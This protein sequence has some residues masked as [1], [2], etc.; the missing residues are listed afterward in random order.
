MKGAIEK[1]EEIA[2]T[3]PHCFMPQQFNNPANPDIHRRTTAQEIWA[4][5]DGNLDM[6]L[7][8]VG[9]GGT[10]S[11]VGE[12]L[13]KKKPSIKV[14]AI[15]PADSPV[16]S[17]GKPG[18]HKIQGIGAGFVPQNYHADVIDEVI[19]VTHQDAGL[20]ARELAR[21]EGILVGISS[22]AIVWAALEAAKR[23]ENAGKT[24]VAMTC[25]TGE[26][27]LSTW[28]FQDESA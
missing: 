4:D 12:F 7:A 1:A 10:V 18:P 26:R 8:G 28:L 2:Q 13:K 14:I 17:G 21:K 15:E 25:D 27:Y 16:L 20:I 9:T 5:T 6:F 23:P 22:G 3:T 24:I 11:G 19:Q